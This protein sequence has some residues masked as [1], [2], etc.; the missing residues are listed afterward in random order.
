[1]AKIGTWKQRAIA[2]VTSST[3]PLAELEELLKVEVKIYSD[4]YL[5][6]PIDTDPTTLTAD[7]LDF[8]MASIPGW[9]PQEGHLE[10]WLIEVLARME[11]ETR[12]VAS[13]V[14]VS[15]FGSSAS[16]C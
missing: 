3:D 16:H 5:D 7:A 11:A 4:S 6:L 15:I 8:L 1:M 12:D 10:V 14:P 9:V 13:R 2:K